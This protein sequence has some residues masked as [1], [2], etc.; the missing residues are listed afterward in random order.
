MVNTERVFIQKMKKIVYP[1]NPPFHPDVAYPEYPFKSIF[2]KKNDIYESF[3]E[4]LYLMELDKK[5]WNTKNWNPFKNIISP[6][7]NVLIKPNL[8]ID[9]EENQEC[10]TTHPSLIRAII[11]YVVIA[12]KRDG[13]IVIGDAPLQQCDFI[14]LTKNTGLLQVIDFIKSKNINIKLIDF[15]TEK[16]VTNTK[17]IFTK[18]TH[19]KKN[20]RTKKLK[21]DPNGY[22]VIDLRKDSNLQNISYNN[23][24]KKF[25]VTDYDP[26]LMKK[27]HNMRNH[28]YLISNSVLKADI[29]I[30]VPK[31]KTHRKAGFT[32]C[33]KNNIG[34]NCHKDWLPHHRKGSYCKGGD[35]YLKASV[36]KKIYVNLY[37]LS[38]YFLVRIPFVYKISYYPILFANFG[39]NLIRKILEDDNYFQG[40][41]YGND[42]IWRTIADLNQILLYTDKKGNLTFVPQRKRFY[43]CDGIIGGEDEGPLEPTPK[44]MGILIAGF[45]PLITD[46]A[47]V[48]VLN[49][50]FKKI[51]Q[52]NKIFKIKKRKISNNKPKDLLIISN[53]KNLNKKGI[54]EL[55]ETI[56]FNP[57]NGWKNHIE[58]LD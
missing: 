47:I 27:V 40:S 24:Y 8:V 41:W 11:D 49:F 48:E 1:K 19:L 18:L 42:T 17:T 45:D 14:K 23:G 57:S 26:T 32:A 46:L 34:I 30:N 22:T 21:G 55:K 7:D 56:K 20:I 58:K 54:N 16:M 31:I 5:N 6:G 15:R 39:L 13:E 52:L 43:I 44:K 50:N 51:P 38:N 4:L 12:L 53:N 29:V 33:L 10:I 9:N 28:K 35:E 37:E 36:L 25:R 2:K 3:R